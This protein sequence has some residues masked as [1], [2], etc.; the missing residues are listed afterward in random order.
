MSDKNLAVDS[1]LFDVSN[2]NVHNRSATLLIAILLQAIQDAT[3]RESS[4]RDRYDATEWLCDEDN[5][6][7]QLCLDVANISYD[8]VLQKVAKDG[9]NLNL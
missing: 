4:M 3:Y 2:P 8:T 6:L 9:W 1:A 7:L 5:K